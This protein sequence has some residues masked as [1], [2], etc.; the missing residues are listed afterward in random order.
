MAQHSPTLQFFCVLLGMVFH[1]L[2]NMYIY[3]ANSNNSQKNY[4]VLAWFTRFLKYLGTIHDSTPLGKNPPGRTWSWGLLAVCRMKVTISRKSWT[5]NETKK[6][7]LIT[8]DVHDFSTM[9]PSTNLENLWS[10][11][12]WNQQNLCVNLDFQGYSEQLKIKFPGF[13]WNVIFRVVVVYDE[14]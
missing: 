12:Q 11:C 7:S 2:F 3:L 4:G 10:I 5:C 1:D 13:C 6:T 14:C 9:L 8:G